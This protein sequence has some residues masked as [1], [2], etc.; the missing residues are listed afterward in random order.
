M[1][2]A[3]ADALDAE[4]PPPGVRRRAIPGDAILHPLSI[5][6]IVVLLVNDQVLKAVAPG[7][8]TGKL[9]DVA[10]L[11]FFPLLL[12]A[13]AEVIA[14]VGGRWH[15]PSR[16]WTTVA[17]VGTGLAFAIVKLVP[18]GE[19][20]YEMV[21]GAAQ[22]P[23]RAVTAVVTGTGAVP[24]VAPVELTR[25]PTDVV[26]LPAVW[27]ALEI[28]ARRARAWGAATGVAGQATP[29]AT[30]TTASTTATLRPDDLAVAVLS[31]VLLAGAILDGWAHT[32]ELLALES[33][34][35]PWHAVVYLGYTA[36]A[37]VLLARPAAGWLE[38]GGWT[39]ARSAI[40]DGYGLS[41][42]G[43]FAFLG[44]GIA[45]AAWH[46]AF[47]IE[48]DA[49]A[50]LSPTHLGLGL[51]AALMASG[52]VRAAWDRRDPTGIPEPAVWPAFLPAALSVVA[53]AGVVAFALHVANVFVDPWPRYPYELDDVTWYG[54]HIGVA[55]A[56]LPVA[57]IMAPTLILLAR[58]PAL[59]PGT[60]TLLV[61]GTLGGLTFLHDASELVGAPVLGGFLADLLLLV[62][63]PGRGGWRLQL[64]AVL[65]PVAILAA[66]F[67]V[68]RATGPVAWSAHLIGGSIVLAAGAGWVLALMVGVRT[69][70]AR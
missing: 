18:A 36:I 31:I 5:A 43:V 47:G 6:A 14:A 56:I 21:L 67:V 25:D 32:H 3:R 20:L 11:V 58:W 49:E 35:T 65:V 69:P 45:D 26:A 22:W 29:T 13:V 1:S 42:A 59:P 12:V 39:G 48:A 34:I 70:A 41:V 57:I 4:V 46:L 9:S 60:L 2:V 38:R 19:A 15:G 27:L 61:G 53:I 64:F 50:L 10:G 51:A 63:R 62:L 52:P 8:V 24:G 33:L 7:A 37:F 66:Y 44:V 68:L 54:P 30:P 17:V 55:S 40:P 28:G 16:R 23:F